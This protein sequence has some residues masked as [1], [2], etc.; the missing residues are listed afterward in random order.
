MHKD[1]YPSYKWYMDMKQC[2]NSQSKY[3]SI[4]THTLFMYFSNFSFF[5]FSILESTHTHTRKKK[6][7]RKIMQCMKEWFPKK[8][9]QTQIRN[10][11]WKFYIR[12]KEFKHRTY[13]NG[14]NLSIGINFLDPSSLT[15]HESL[16]VKMERHA[17]Y[18]SNK[19]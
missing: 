17:S 11:P 6:K 12:W 18:M 2:F 9:W 10:Q 19:G 3:T 4:N 14:K 16:A 1:A 7:K 13:K 15:Q 8:C 5:Y